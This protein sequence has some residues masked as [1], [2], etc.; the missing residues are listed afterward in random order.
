MRDLEVSNSREERFFSWTKGYLHRI[1]RLS[2]QHADDLFGVKAELS[3]NYLLDDRVA[4][5]GVIAVGIGGGIP[6][7]R[8][9]FLAVRVATTSHEAL[10]TLPKRVHGIPVVGEVLGEFHAQRRCRPVH[11]GVS[12]GLASAAAL[13][14]TLAGFVAIRGGTYALSAAHVLCPPVAGTQIDVVQPG[15]AD[16]GSMT[17]DVIATSKYA[18]WEHDGIDA[19]VAR[20]NPNIDVNCR[21]KFKYHSRRIYSPVRSPF[22]D[23][24][25][26]KI[27][28]RTMHTS[29]TVIVIGLDLKVKYRDGS[30]KLLRNQFLVEG[31]G[32]KFTDHGDSGSL[33]FSRSGRRPVGMVVAGNNVAS[34]CAPMANIL[35]KF[36]ADFRF[37]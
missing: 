10:A 2:Q 33:V 12:V 29:G 25:V 16:N 26:C 17:G 15:I 31:R 18:S 9:G 19:H 1:L 21:L 36:N 8:S 11:A 23:M 14:G 35:T 24:S 6:G 20:L 32:G 4:E 30:R 5:Q 37:K 27:G 3:R 22:I 13:P 34:V 28:K 7:Q